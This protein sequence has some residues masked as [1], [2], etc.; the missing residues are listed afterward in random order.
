MSAARVG[1]VVAGVADGLLRMPVLDGA[2]TLAR[3]LGT[4]LRL[5]HGHDPGDRA[6]WQEDAGLRAEAYV[7]RTAPGLDVRRTCPEGEEPADALV[8]A[9]ADA[10]VLVLGDRKGRLGSDAGRTT[11]EVIARAPCPVLVHGEDRGRMSGSVRRV[12][13]VGVDGSSHAAVVLRLGLEAAAMLGCSLDAI[14]VC[15]DVVPVEHRLVRHEVDPD[16]LARA[17]RELDTLV[18]GLA[19]GTVPVS[20][21]AVADRPARAL[22][23]AGRGAALIVVG[24]GAHDEPRPQRLGST[25]RAVLAAA[26]CPVLV[27]GPRADIRR[28][29]DASVAEALRDA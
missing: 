20:T 26:T 1:P 5:V 11:D 7:R 16:A 25:A 21:R 9:A 18:G 13:V 23:E 6:A 17:H 8:D 29:V 12:V 28:D 10:A 4:G 14:R 3:R 27:V 24:H 2:V 15:E 19:S 22:L